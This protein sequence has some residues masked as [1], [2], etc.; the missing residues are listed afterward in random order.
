MAAA[1]RSTISFGVLV[2]PSASGSSVWMLG[3]AAATL[4]TTRAGVNPTPSSPRSPSET[5]WNSTCS[6]SR[7]GTRDSSSRSAAH[8]ASP[9]VS[10]VVSTVTTLASLIGGVLL[11]ASS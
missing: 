3:R 6:R 1:I 9:T 4:A 11:R 8:L 2:T 7:P 10:P 5:T